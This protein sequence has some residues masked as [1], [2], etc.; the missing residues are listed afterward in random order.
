MEEHIK[1]SIIT[2][3]KN[4]AATIEQT[5]QSVISQTYR[6]IEYIV[7]DGLSTDET[8]PIVKRYRQHID[9]LISEKD[10][11]IYDAMNKG[12]GAA[13]GDII[14]FL[15]ANDYMFDEKSIE[16]VASFINEHRPMN[17]D[18]YYGGVL[19][20]DYQKR[21]GFVW[22]SAPISSFFIHNQPLSHPATFYT[23]AA[24]E[25]N[26]K[27]DTSFRIMGDYEW[28]IRALKRN[29]LHFQFMPQVTTIF[30]KRGISNHPATASLVRAETRRAITTHFTFTEDTFHRIRKQLRKARFRLCRLL[31]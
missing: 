4:A 21:N 9:V 10:H 30:S 7:V 1:F 13:T 24:F 11:G 27:F 20:F 8:L 3:C 25:K 2:V 22:K 14:S 16:C 19:V 6:N 5:I 28:T 23:R 26:G 12:L 15:N 29:G 18:V 17:I 31:F